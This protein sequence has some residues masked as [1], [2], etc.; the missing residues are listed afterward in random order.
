MKKKYW[1]EIIVFSTIIIVALI[2]GISIYNSNNSNREKTEEG[3]RS[4][5]VETLEKDDGWYYTLEINKVKDESGNEKI[6]SIF[7]GCN[8]KYETLDDNYITMTDDNGNIVGSIP[9]APPSLNTSYR[10]KDNIKTE[11][12]EVQEINDLL[13]RLSFDREWNENDFESLEL[14]NIDA[15]DIITLGNNTYHKDY[16]TNFEKYNNIPECAFLKETK[17]NSY[18]QVGIHQSYGEIDVVRIDYVD[19]N[20]MYLSDKI[21]N[22]T[23]NET[24]KNQYQTI[25]EIA[26]KVIETQDLSLQSQYEELRN[27]ETYQELFYLLQEMHMKALSEE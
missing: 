2:V 8:L 22:D 14:V 7:N 5:K 19:E 3:L 18:Y 17:E 24:E 10:S 25:Q 11:A 9:M 26:N 13:T 23:A 15:N 21:Q 1:I 6:S 27:D 16:K 20:G 12:S 4:F